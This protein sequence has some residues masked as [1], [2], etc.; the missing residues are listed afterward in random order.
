MIR[1]PILILLW[2][3]TAAGCSGHFFPPPPAPSTIETERFVIVTA[4]PQDTFTSLAQTYLTDADKAWQIAAYNRIDSPAPDQRVVIPRIP[5]NLGGITP[6]GFQT[7][8]VLLY[9]ELTT[10]PSKS[11]AVKARDF[12]RQLQYL[13]D[14]EFT[15][16]SLDQFHAFLCLKD[17][18][19]SKAVIISFDTTRSWVYEI[20]FPLLRHRKM[21]AALFLRTDEIGNKGRLNWA[22]IA[23]IAAEGFEIGVQGEKFKPPGNEDLN[24]YFKAYE[25]KISAPQNVFK[26]HL[27]KTCPYFAYADGKSNDPTIAILKKHGYRMAFTRKRG[28]SPFFVDNYKIRRS[29]IHGRYDMAQFRQN[30]VTF[31]TAGLK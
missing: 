24:H 28:S 17:Q 29:V 22:Q 9:P 25:K 5:F 16:I 26:A 27:K 13:E 31:Q 21:K 7:V 20:A 30:L 14:N 3:I 1:L 15:T 11:K 19:P 2:A 18:L 23:E 12:D 6:N 4:G 8:P 10:T